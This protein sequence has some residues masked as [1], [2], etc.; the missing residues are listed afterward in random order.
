MLRHKADRKTVVYMVLTT[1][2][3]FYL[4]NSENLNPFGWAAL[5]VIHLGF[6]VSASVIAH[7]H[8][9]VNMWKSKFMNVFQD[10]W[11]TIFY[12]F[13]VWAWI[14][15]HNRNHHR[16]VNTEP[17]YT[18]TWRFTESNNIATLLSYPSISGRFQMPALKQYLKNQY[19]NHRGN[20]WLCI[21]QIVT[22]VV[23]VA[24]GLILD[25]KKAILY[26]IL[27]QQ[28]STFAV[29][30]FNYVQH[31]HADELSE[32]NHSR[33]F[34]GKFLNFHLLNNGYHTAHHMKASTH[35][36]ELPAEHAKIHDKIDPRLNEKSFWGYIF[37]VYILGAISPK[38]STYN[39]RMARKSNRNS[40]DS[41]KAESELAV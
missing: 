41:M 14:P 22:L 9:H 18:R 31:I 6:A 3:F 12:G 16:H 40:N 25:W 38:Y 36:S 39:F 1:A 10:N 2:V 37:R 5:Y 15:T 34:L 20:F 17:D 33:N 19:Q 28:L 27:P 35:W 23:W 7:N 21:L 8:N 4:W 30:I 29:L 32:F 26:I 24:G 13:P 11:T